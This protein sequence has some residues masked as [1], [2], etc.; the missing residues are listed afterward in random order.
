ALT[1]FYR[2]QQERDEDYLE[3][4]AKAEE[5]FQED[6]QQREQSF[7]DRLRRIWEQARISILEA[8]SRLD[9]SAVIE[10][11]RRRDMEMREQQEDRYKERDER[12]KAFEEQRADQEAQY[13]K[14]RQRQQQEFNLRLQREDQDRSLRLQRQYEDYRLQDQRRQ[15]D[16]N[17]RI[18]QLIQHNNIMQSIT[19]VGY[20]NMRASW[21]GLL[22]WMNANMG[23]FHFPTNNTQYSGVHGVGGGGSGKQLTPLAVGTPRLL[24]DG[25]VY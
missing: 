16:F 24:S 20:S 4:R 19:E 9:A 5:D 14:Q 13:Q 12:L 1:D 17:A 18:H 2:Q 11:Q 3:D 6:T 15:E 25:I 21:R 8:A 7:Q 10:Q 23:M 22:D